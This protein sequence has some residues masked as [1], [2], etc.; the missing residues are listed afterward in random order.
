MLSPLTEVAIVLGGLLGVAIGVFWVNRRPASAAEPAIAPPPPAAELAP[1]HARR[2]DALAATGFFA[3]APAE[4]LDAMR[5]AFCRTKAL[6]PLVD[7]QL[8]FFDEQEL[9]ECGVGDLIEALRPRLEALGV[10]L[11]VVQHKA[12]PG[13]QVDVTIDGRRHELLEP[14][15]TD[16]LEEAASRVTEAAFSLLNDMLVTAGVPER[17][18]RLRDTFDATV[19]ILSPAQ[20]E[21]IAHVTALTG[22]VS[23][24][25]PVPA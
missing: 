10:K 3:P 21:A 11:G 13:L 14:G 15:E 6:W 23:P 7:A 1:E 18:Y 25:R 17:A 24:E 8:A 12:V 22:E 19:A 2:F 9:G 20:A 16:T 4:R 5:E